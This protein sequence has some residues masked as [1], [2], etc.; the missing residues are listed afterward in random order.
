MISQ[1]YCMGMDANEPVGTLAPESRR[2]IEGLV[3]SFDL[4]RF[5]PD[6]LTGGLPDGC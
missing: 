6:K 1:A 3:E 2:F 4:T 5:H